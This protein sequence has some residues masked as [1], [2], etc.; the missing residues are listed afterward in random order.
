MFPQCLGKSKNILYSIDI[1]IASSCV[2][3]YN[4]TI[5]PYKCIIYHYKIGSKAMQEK[6]LKAKRY[7]RKKCV[8]FITNLIL[9]GEV[10]KNQSSQ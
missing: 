5:S 9:F 4:S 8:I 7:N 6:N 10:L 3:G 2:T 1:N